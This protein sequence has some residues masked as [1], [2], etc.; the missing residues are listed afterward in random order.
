M[1]LKST[2]PSGAYESSLI[3]TDA[4]FRWDKELHKLSHYFV[5][6]FLN[7]FFLFPLNNGISLA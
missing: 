7:D 5:G 4:I 6:Q 1:P 3:P 2:V